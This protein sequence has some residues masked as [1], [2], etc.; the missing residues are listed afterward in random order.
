MI[1]TLLPWESRDHLEPLGI[2]C[3]DLDV[4]SEEST[5]AFK[6]AIDELTGGRLDVLVNNA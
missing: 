4:T 6:V 5:A 1:A 3:F 2:K